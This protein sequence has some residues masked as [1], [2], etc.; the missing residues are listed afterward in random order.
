[1]PKCDFNEIALRHGCSLVSLLHIFRTLFSK[2]S[3]GWLFLSYVAHWIIRIIPYSNFIK[4]VISGCSVNIKN[5][6]ADNEDMKIDKFLRKYL[7]VDKCDL[8]LF[9]ALK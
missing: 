6:N 2:N 9:H 4:N 5:L 7:M 8:Y 1:M 3:S